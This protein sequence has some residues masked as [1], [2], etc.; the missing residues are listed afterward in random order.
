MVSENNRNTLQTAIIEIDTDDALLSANDLFYKQ[1]GYNNVTGMLVDSL[2]TL[3]YKK[4]WL[5]IRNHLL[6]T[7]TDVYQTELQI[8]K[9]DKTTLTYCCQIIKLP[10]KNQSS[11]QMVV[12]AKLIS[13]NGVN[14]ARIEFPDKLPL[15][16]MYAF[17][18]SEK[19]VKCCMQ[20][21]Y[22]DA[23]LKWKFNAIHCSFTAQ[24][25]PGDLCILYRSFDNLLTRPLEI[26][27]C[28][29]RMTLNS[30]NWHEVFN[31]S[32][33]P[34]Q[35]SNDGSKVIAGI[36]MHTSKD[37]ETLGMFNLD[38]D[39]MMKNIPHGIAVTKA[40]GEIVFVNQTFIELSG[41]QSNQLTGHYLSNFFCDIKDKNE[42]DEFCSYAV[43]EEPEPAEMYYQFKKSDD[44]VIDL[45][46]HWNYMR[47]AEQDISGF[48]FKIS[49]ISELRMIKDMIHNVP[50]P[51]KLLMANK[52]K[53]LLKAIKKM[54]TEINERRKTEKLLKES[55]SKLRSI[56][57]HSQDGIFLT[58]ENGTIIEWNKGQENITGIPRGE[59]INRKASKIMSYIIK[60]QGK[61]VSEQRINQS[62]NEILNTGQSSVIK[63]NK[64][65]EYELLDIANN[66]HVVQ[67]V[68]FVIPTLLG[69]RMASINRDVTEQRIKELTI[70]KSQE[71]L[72]AIFDNSQQA[73]V[74]IDKNLTIKIF[75][76]RFYN[77][78][79]E[80]F[81]K[82]IQEGIGIHDIL[83]ETMVNEFKQEFHDVLQGKPLQIEHQINYSNSMY[84]WYRFHYLP[85]YKDN[86]VEDVFICITDIHK[87]KKA[88][89]KLQK[90]LNREKELNKLKSRF[91]SVVSH[92]F[93]TPLA[94]MVSSAQLLEKYDTKWSESRKKKVFERIYKSANY[95]KMLLNELSVIGKDENGGL[96]FQPDILHVGKFFK[97]IIDEVQ[98]T[99]NK[100]VIHF[101]VQLP[102]SEYFLDKRLLHHILINLLTN[103]IKYSSEN[104]DIKFSITCL[105]KR[106]I[107]FQVR[108]NGIGIPGNDLSYLFEPFHRG[109]NVNDIAGTGLGLSIVKRC[110]ELHN[111]QIQIE[112]TQS[113]GT[114]AEV[115]IP[116]THIK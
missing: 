30:K 68:E 55:E 58:D 62:V 90:A 18:V 61:E 98:L 50:E 2:F 74:V 22:C 64:V 99:F 112:S 67:S 94:G 29:L 115:I 91:I 87:Q 60:R 24:I 11:A 106:N 54:E 37:I 8:V 75:N 93:R 49:D 31:I 51:N 104:Q 116:I 73:Y 86:R 53:V 52:S 77:G 34:Q 47:N 36:I 71:Q 108:D 97:D 70:K 17:D 35:I 114:L 6:T 84:R 19:R 88:E 38:T 107:L 76:R 66:T 33:L 72:Q 83:P 82:R 81:G 109:E 27:R 113:K 101:S 41:Y 44:S 46:I 32:W 43:K 3:E 79:F 10:D 65:S 56:L 1:T 16:L 103:A 28:T 9:S 21:V 26:L 80:L 14:E 23:E 25:H 110:V 7:E 105:N 85:I 100:A 15:P 63:L 69:F 95:L 92:E 42:F 57:D 59:V 96:Q 78:T 45:R 89:E 39:Q 20:S 48:M 4:K 5:S 40:T 13:E 12:T 102:Q 111:G